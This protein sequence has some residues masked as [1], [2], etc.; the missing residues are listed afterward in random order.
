MKDVE[1]LGVVMGWFQWDMRVY[2][3]PTQPIIE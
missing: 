1:K 2:E 3:N